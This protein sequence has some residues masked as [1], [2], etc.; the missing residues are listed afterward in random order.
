[1]H[2]IYNKIISENFPNLKNKIKFEYTK[3]IGLEIYKI[4]RDPFQDTSF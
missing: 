4:A 1:M 3:H 2:N